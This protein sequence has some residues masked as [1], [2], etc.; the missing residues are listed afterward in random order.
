MINTFFAFCSA[1]PCAPQNV[2]ASLVCLTNSALVSWVGSPSAL[3]YNVTLV[4][5]DGH[6]HCCQTNSSTCQIPSIHCGESYS[7]TVVPYSETCAGQ[8]SDVYTFR[9]GTDRPLEV[10]L[11]YLIPKRNLNPEHILCRSLCSPKRHRVLS[12]PGPPCLLVSSSRG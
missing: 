2:S 11:F 8:Q 4:G 7:I 9:T 1:V 6:L 12:W 5:Q 3:W 10:I